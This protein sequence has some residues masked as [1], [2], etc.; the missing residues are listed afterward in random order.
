MGIFPLPESQLDR[1]LFKIT[2]DYGSPEEE[3]SILRQ[4]HRGLAPDLLGEVLPLLDVVKLDAAQRELDGTVVS[5]EAARF[6]VAVARETRKHPHVILG[7]SPRAAVHLQSAAKARARLDGRDSVSPDDVEAV[8]S[9]VLAHRLMLKSGD[10][11]E[12]VA[13]AVAAARAA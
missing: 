5:D 11:R 7:A 1:F 13:D 4:P 3:M 10:A 9:A 2:L 8:A 12:V 6:V